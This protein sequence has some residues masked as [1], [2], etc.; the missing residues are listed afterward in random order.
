MTLPWDRPT[1]RIH[2][3]KKIK[4]KKSISKAKE[5][6]VNQWNEAFWAASSKC[7]RHKIF[8]HWVEE[9]KTLF[10]QALQLVKEPIHPIRV[11]TD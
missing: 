9:Q 3:I 10:K 5:C 4:N 2:R 8:A 1:T 6:E 11:Q 7:N